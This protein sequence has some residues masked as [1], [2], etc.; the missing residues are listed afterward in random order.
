METKDMMNYWEPYG[1]I[2]EQKRKKEKL[3]D[4]RQ[5]THLL[6]KKH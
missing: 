3:I 6:E 5:S 1:N 2:E 4:R